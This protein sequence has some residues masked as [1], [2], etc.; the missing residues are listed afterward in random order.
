MFK[1]SVANYSLWPEQRPRRGRPLKFAAGSFVLGVVCATAYGALFNFTNPATGQSLG[2]ERVVEPV[3]IV[4]ER[5]PV[6]EAAAPVPTAETESR[7]IRSRAAAAKVTLPLI[8][9]PSRQPPAATSGRGDDG[10][11]GEVRLTDPEAGDDNVPSLLGD[12]KEQAARKAPPARTVE[13]APAPKAGEP[14]ATVPVP[15]AAPPKTAAAKDAEPAA[16]QAAAASQPMRERKGEQAAVEQAARVPAAPETKTR[17]AQPAAAAASTERRGLVLAMREEPLELAGGDAPPARERSATN[18]KPPAATPAATVETRTARPGVVVLAK[19]EQTTASAGGDERP[20]RT[21]TIRTTKTD[22]AEPAAATETSAKRRGYVVLKK[23]EQPIKLARAN[24]GP[25]REPVVRRSKSRKA[26][27]AVASEQRAKPR[28]S[29]ARKQMK[30]P[31]RVAARA[32]REATTRHAS[33]RRQDRLSSMI[34]QAT[35]AYRAFTA[36]HSFAMP[37]GL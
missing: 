33:G 1:R 7:P 13:P 5:Q 28:S 30:Q 34:A 9:A 12:T 18:G 32:K 10:L 29:V 20:A 17:A 36:G 16:R 27:N 8:G 37:A 14:A 21:P 25:E 23:R 31:T 2:V 15:R 11:S 35:R 4:I 6:V 3:P 26:T 19:R 24:E 22:A